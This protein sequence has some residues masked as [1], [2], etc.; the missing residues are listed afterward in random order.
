MHSH[1]KR[2][3]G[4]NGTSLEHAH[5]LNQRVILETIRLHGPVSRV[6]IARITSLTNQTVFN[7]VEAGADR[8]HSE[9]AVP[10]LRCHAQA[11]F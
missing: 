4:R 3:V 11:G 8:R 10:W 7:I 2:T 9:A 1:Q 6:E 5:L